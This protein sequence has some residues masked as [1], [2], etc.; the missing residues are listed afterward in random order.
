MLESQVLFSELTTELDCGAGLRVDREQWDR[1]S[2]P[3]TNPTFVIEFFV[4]LFV[5]PGKPNYIWEAARTY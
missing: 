5:L 2:S 4:C 1:L 3:D